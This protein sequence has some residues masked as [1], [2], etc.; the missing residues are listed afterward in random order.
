MLF[1]TTTL[2]ASLQ[3]RILNSQQNHLHYAHQQFKTPVRPKNALKCKMFIDYRKTFFSRRL[4]ASTFHNRT[5]ASNFTWRLRLK[6]SS[7]G[8]DESFQSWYIRFFRPVSVMEHLV[9]RDDT[10]SLICNQWTRLL[11]TSLVTSEQLIE[12][13][14][15]T[16]SY[17]TS[18]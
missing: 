3:A 10:E 9:I 18:S 6:V 12:R 16:T 14:I 4:A 1:I 5:D 8:H 11:T 13:S 7:S 2:I 15:P 17:V